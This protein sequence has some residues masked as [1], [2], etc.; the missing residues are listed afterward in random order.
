MSLPEC[1]AIAPVHRL[2]AVQDFLH[3]ARQQMFGTLVD[4]QQTPADLQHFEQVYAAGT[5]GMW[6]ARHPQHGM[7]GSIA[8]RAYDGRFAQLDFGAL[9]VVEVVRLFVAPVW[10][11]Q[12]LAVAL[13][14]H[15]RQ[16]AI[17]QGVQLLYLHTHPFLP[18]ALEFW[19]QQGFEVVQRETAAPWHTI[20]MQCAL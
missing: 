19:L 17:A 16:H 8:Y 5:G 15:V 18:G 4:P 6:A 2:E 10:R 20:H 11:R 12:G 9:R 13:L 14:D 1:M 3:M 7:V